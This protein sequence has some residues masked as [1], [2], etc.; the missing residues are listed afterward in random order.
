MPPTIE[1][2]PFSAA[3]PASAIKPVLL[4]AFLLYLIIAAYTMLH[5]E[6]WGDE[7]HSWNMARDSNSLADLMHHKRYEGHPP[8]WNLILWLTSKATHSLFWMQVIHLAIATLVVGLILFYAP[9]PVFARVLLPFGYYFLYE[10]AILSRNYAIGVLFALLLCMVLKKEFRYRPLLYYTL[11]LFLSN[12][13]LLALL[14]AVSLHLYWLMHMRGNSGKA[15]VLHALLGILVL[16]P[17]ALFILP[18]SDTD[19]SI[20]SSLE[21]WRPDRAL[22]ALQTPLRAFVPLP[23]WWKYEFWNWQF[24][25]E[26]NAHF[27]IMKVISPLM[28]LGF[29]LLGLYLLK[30]SRKSQALFGVNTILTFMAGFIYP[31][32]T[33]RYTG[34]IFI[35]F[36]VAY[37]L[38]C[39]YKPVSRSKSKIIAVL[40][41]IQMIAGI[42]IVAKD[43]SLPFSNF[44]RTKELLGKVP[45]G[46]PVVTEYWALIAGS[47]YLDRP[48]YCIDL[49]QQKSFIMWDA[50]MAAMTKKPSRYYDG[51]TAF[52]SKHSVKE[53]YFFSAS[54]PEILRS[55]D[56]RLFSSFRVLEVAKIEGAIEKWSNLYLYRIRTL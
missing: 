52:F 43:S 12:T 50:G 14:L 2:L 10:Y 37:W 44:Y 25:L 5:H 26:G 8:I 46:K 54:S 23:A 29:I 32:G 13:H 20:V 16:L 27:K 34:F 56:A 41:A 24:I 6:L 31:L 3:R 4:A 30:G 28:A 11:L 35:G 39:Y 42:F 40:L 22:I 55:I 1:P 45:P 36:I 21:R 51:F 38:H 7:L 18:P 19:L 53:V 15:I 47:A 33:Q 48:F 17:A 9:F 49:Q